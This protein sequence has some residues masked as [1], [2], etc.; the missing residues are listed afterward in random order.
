M[1]TG[2][3]PGFHLLIAFE[4]CARHA[5]FAQA[6]GELNVTPSAISHRIR[7]LEENLGEALFV[8]RGRRVE[9]TIAGARYLDDVRD[10]LERLSRLARPKLGDHARERLRIASPPT[11]ARQLLA[12]RLGAFHAAHPAIDTEL[13]LSIPFSEVKGAD[14]DVEIRF[15]DGR[16]PGL[17]AHKLFDETLFPVASVA[18]ARSLAPRGMLTPE[19]IAKA[20]LLRNP[21]D[22][23]KVWFAAAG[24]EAAEPRGGPLFNDLGLLVEAAAQGQGVALARSVLSR[25]WLESRAVVRLSPIEAASSNAYYVLVTEAN[26]KRP[27]VRA[28]ADWILA[29]RF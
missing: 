24:I 22:P 25:G 8:R 10:A 5:S 2:S 13:S 1:K 14:A 19:E 11:F 15:G 7:D 18:Y 9:L 3:V 12:P 4:A 21:R 27:A 26:A 20:T 28:F 17:T 23:W 6:A 29:A 16:F